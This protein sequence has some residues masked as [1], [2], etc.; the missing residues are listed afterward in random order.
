MTGLPAAHVFEVQ[1]APG[2]WTDVTGW[3][4]GEDDTEL[5]FGR[6]TEFQEPEAITLD[7]QLRNGDGRFTPDNP[8]SPYWP[9]ITE[10]NPVRMTVVLGG[11]AVGGA[12]YGSATYGTAVYGAGS[13]GGTTY[14]GTGASYVRFVGKVTTWDVDFPTG[15]AY[16]G[17][18]TV[19]ASDALGA[20]ANRELEAEQLEQAVTRALAAGSW[21][22]VYSFS[23]AQSVTAF[24]NV[25]VPTP[26]GQLGTATLV[27]AV[28]R[29]GTATAGTAD[30]GIATETMLTF[31]VSNVYSGPYLRVVPGGGDVKVVDL[32]FR[33]PA[34][35]VA[36]PSKN[37][38]VLDVYQGGRNLL[39]VAVGLAGGLSAL[40]LIDPA[41]NTYTTLRASIADGQWHRLS[42]AWDGVFGTNVVLDGRTVNSTVIM[43]A[44]TALYLGGIGSP[45]AEGRQ[46]RNLPMDLAGLTIQGFD[47]IGSANISAPE[48]VTDL[49]RWASLAALVDPGLAPVGVAGT[50]TA[51]PYATGAVVTHGTDTWVAV[52]PSTAVTPG[53]DPGKW[54]RETRRMVWPTSTAGRTVL[55]AMQVLARTTGGYVWQTPA[56]VLTYVPPEYALPSSVLATVTLDLDDDASSPPV[57]RRSGETRPTR[58]TVSSPVATATAVD[59]TAEIG[60][61]RRE[62]TLD[63]AAASSADAYSL[64]A[65]RLL[66][67]NRL[68]LAQLQVDLS[69]STAD[70]YELL[71]GGLAPGA[72]LRI[73]G[74]PSTVFGASYTEVH[75]QGW[76]ERWSATDAVLTFD[77]TPADDPPGARFD[78][79]TY[80]RFAADPGTQLAHAITAGATSVT[81]TSGTPF[82]TAGGDMPFSLDLGGERVT[83]SAVSSPSTSLATTPAQRRNLAAAPSFENAFG[84]LWS[85]ATSGYVTSAVARSTVRAS[86]GVASMRITWPS[87]AAQASGAF[88]VLTG[89]T[90]GQRYSCSLDVWV[91]LGSPA[92]RIFER[93]GTGGTVTYAPRTSGTTKAAWTRLAMSFT[94][95]ATTHDLGVGNEESVAS[96]R[97]C[98]VD[99]VLVEPTTAGPGAYFDGTSPGGSWTG[100]AGA[101]ESRQNVQTLTLSARGVAP[102]IAR[103]H[104]AGEPIDVWLAATFAP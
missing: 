38:G 7:F 61:A 92:V 50:W 53:T 32:Y 87:A 68:R 72:R 20:L 26:G 94:A 11:P 39:Q 62:I 47:G 54:A 46:V 55:D 34:G 97:Q 88:L 13:Y 77:C 2:T 19:Q 96:G 23:G 69:T 95:T 56:G 29:L 93:A 80:G 70:L 103:A 101:S 51:G 21:V 57:W 1:F 14:A 86:S 25:G 6:P 102:T 10:D 30:G 12:T 35:F 40:Y 36:P 9:Y 84:P 15:A 58:V 42:L 75:V 91:P 82:T 99:S 41:T 22:D 44:A 98:W 28:S 3:V 76:S 31:G 83:V 59:T 5:R 8:A 4:V 73:A 33:V 49:A 18:V 67:S 89:L 27:P 100:T 79:A 65:G 17:V 48:P 43:R 52:A 85:G 24:A 63:T 74:L 37:L 45:S 81:V 64:A 60:G 90:I 71:L 16:D 104:P 66:T 78:D